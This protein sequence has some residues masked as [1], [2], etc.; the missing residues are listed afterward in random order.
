MFG[1][2]ILKEITLILN[3]FFKNVPQ[4]YPFFNSVRCT[5]DL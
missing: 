5:L 4:L 3:N 1:K 2:N